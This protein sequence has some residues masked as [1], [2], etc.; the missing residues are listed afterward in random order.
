ML[1]NPSHVLKILFLSL[2]S[3]FL[4]SA[5]SSVSFQDKKT[6]EEVGFEYFPAKPYLVV[7]ENEKGERSVVLISLP[8]VSR[9]H[10]VKHKG[11]WGTLDFNFTVS[12]GMIT[13]FGQKVDSKGPETIEAVTGG[14]AAVASVMGVPGF[15]P[16]EEGFFLRD[17]GVKQLAGELEENV[18]KPLELDLDTKL[19]KIATNLTKPR[20]ALKAAANI[21]VTQTIE[22]PALVE[23]RRQSLVAALEELKKSL[24]ILTVFTDNLQN[25]NPSMQVA[26]DAKYHL[27][28]IIKRLI[29]F[30]VGLL[31]NLQIYEIVEM[32]G[33]ISFELVTLP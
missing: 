7:S 29:P 11:G 24:G 3:L 8:D 32:G 22:L 18:I 12:N 33:K 6:G 17:Q 4:L 13:G 27:E 19:Q 20:D 25:E 16:G 2:T 26:L 15:L 28:G 10:E 31:G 5:C 1:I 23:S 14:F 21:P 9:P 30:T